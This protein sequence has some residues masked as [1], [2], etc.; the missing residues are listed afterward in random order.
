MRRGPAPGIGGQPMI[1]TGVAIDVKFE[2]TGPDYCPTEIKK[3]SEWV[4]I[5]DFVIGQ[6]QCC[7]RS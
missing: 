2:V 6:R 1:S 3:H 4:V 7:Q 5:C